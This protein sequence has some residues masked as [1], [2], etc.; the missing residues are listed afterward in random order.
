MA[1]DPADT[2]PTADARFMCNEQLLAV[3]SS[4]KPG[5]RFDAEIAAAKAEIARRIPHDEDLNN[6]I[7]E[8]LADEDARL[9]E[10]LVQ[11]AS[12]DT[13]IRADFSVGA[14]Q[15]QIARDALI[16]AVSQ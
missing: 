15:A 11:I 10:A 14:K 4:T 2:A 1:T 3:V 8:R 9:V 5:G 16:S 6:Q 12:R 7:T 13:G